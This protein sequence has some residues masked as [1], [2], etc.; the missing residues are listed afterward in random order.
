MKFPK[1]MGI[2][3]VTPDSFSDGGKFY[4]KKQAIEWGLSLLEDGADIIDIGGE[5]TRPNA[6]PVSSDE[7]IN[8]VIPV[9]EGILEQKPDTFISIDTM[10]SEVA[11]L[12]VKAGVKMVNDVSGLQNDPRLAEIA[13]KYNVPLVIMHM[14]GTPETMQL[15][16]Y[17][18]DVVEE[19]YNFL[20]SKIDFAKNLGVKEIYADVGIG[21]G[22][23]VEHNWELLRNLEKFYFLDVPLLLGISRKS[24]IGKTL[25]IENPAERDFPTLLL[26]SLL[27]VKNIDII[28]VHNIKQFKYLKILYEQLFKNN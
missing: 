1:L 18:D 22:K 12:A 7:E 21:F 5:S 25:G 11:E 28:R 27:L 13:C 16:P 20:E 24:F 10:K 9:I 14:K 2:L 6:E 19:I 15:N 3:N 23:T 17:Y 8:R 4:N 26:H